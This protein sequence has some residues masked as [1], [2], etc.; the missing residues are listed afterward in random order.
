M[1]QILKRSHSLYGTHY[2]LTIVYKHLDERTAKWMLTR[3]KAEHARCTP[4]QTAT[5]F[6][7]IVT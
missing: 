3:L 7:I 2:D 5:T 1:Y 6:E 4:M